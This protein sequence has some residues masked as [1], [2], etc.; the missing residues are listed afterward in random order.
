MDGE[1]PAHLPVLVDEVTFLLRPRRGGWVVDGTIGMGGHAERLL[2]TAPPATR[3]LGLD[4]DPEAIARAGRRLAGFG[5]RVT[6]RQ[7]SFRSL[8]AHAEAA[9]VGAAETV[10]LDLGLSSYQLGESGRGFS[11]SREEPLDMRFDPTRGATAAELLNSL[12][13]DELARILGEYGE[14]R[15]ARRIARRVA[16][17]RVRAPFA[18]TRDLVEAV[19]RSVPR[20]AWP[21]RLHVATRTFQA[22]RMAVNEELPAL[23]E[24]LPQAAELL[25]VGGRLGVIS[26]HSGEDR[27]VKHT[28]RAL[29]GAGYAPIEPA[30]IQPGED[31]ISD[32]PRA[33][34]AKLRV[35]ERLEAA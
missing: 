31:E 22:M 25:A 4:R 12:P 13:A 24:A 29:A 5:A 3:L 30:P 21:R 16:E 28:F 10:L 8:R 1:A 18:T 27:I 7:G 20:A 33:R 9:G 2:E 34:S 26:F 35:L 15:H 17:T 32:N 6:L 23:A 14:E 11:F 19:Q